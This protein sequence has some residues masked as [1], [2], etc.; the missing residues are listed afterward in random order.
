VVRRVISVVTGPGEAAVGGD[1]VLEANTY[2][3]AEDVDLAIVL[4]AG[5]VEFAVAAVQPSLELAGVTL[6]PTEPAR[7]LR[8]LAESGVAVH[9]EAEALADR[10]LSP[11]DLVPGTTLSE[12][13]AIADLLAT[14]DA[15]LMW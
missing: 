14:A 9:V 15:V 7:D 5:A 4:R 11:D 12:A 3:V 10:G 2:A 8:G 1:S 6:P 13:D